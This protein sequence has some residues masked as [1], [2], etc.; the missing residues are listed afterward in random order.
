MP[1]SSKRSNSEF[2]RILREAMDVEV[3][4]TSLTA[5][6]LA[7]AEERQAAGSVLV[8]WRWALGGGAIALFLGAAAGGLLLLRAEMSQLGLM[9]EIALGNVQAA[10]ML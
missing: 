7:Y 8:P 5:G 6:I 9:I 4:S 2:E 10:G 1:D 3:P